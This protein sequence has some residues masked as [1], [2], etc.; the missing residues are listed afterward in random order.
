LHKETV[1]V[2][3]AADIKDHFAKNGG[4]VLTSTPEAFGAFLKAETSKM[5]KVV[6]AAEIEPE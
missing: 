2:L 6:K 3:R 1:T 5:A 4:E